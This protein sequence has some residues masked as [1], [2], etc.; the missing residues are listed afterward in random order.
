MDWMEILK[1]IAAIASGLAAAIP[2]AIQLVKY[3]K[4]AIKEKNWNQVL[5]KVMSLMETAETK[6]AEGAERKEWVLAMLKAS[7]DG[8]NY[9]ID[10]DAIGEMI[11]RLCDMSK[12]INPAVPA[13]GEAEG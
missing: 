3:V 1:L 2:L 9:D 7:A 11:D 6:F 5:Q 10:Y 4:Q 13:A 12:I 8:I